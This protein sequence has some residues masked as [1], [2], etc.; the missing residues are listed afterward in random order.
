MKNVRVSNWNFMTWTPIQR[1]KEELPKCRA[2]GT[3]C[4]HQSGLPGQIEDG[5]QLARTLGTQLAVSLS[6]I[7][8]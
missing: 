3:D 8:Y 1:R 5:L 7:M 2:G 4:L 6:R